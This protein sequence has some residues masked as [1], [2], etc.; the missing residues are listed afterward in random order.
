MEAVAIDAGAS[1]GQDL[2]DRTLTACAP[3]VNRRAG[4]TGTMQGCPYA[5]GT[6]S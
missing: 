5:S 4:V 6:K 3:T 1:A 2:K